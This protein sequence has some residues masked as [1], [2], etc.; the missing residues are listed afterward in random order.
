MLHF[1]RVVTDKVR[2]LLRSHGQVLAS[3]DIFVA[4]AQVG[5]APLVEMSVVGLQ[6][7]CLWLQVWIGQL[8]PFLLILLILDLLQKLNV[9]L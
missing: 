1:L 9:L 6:T 5:P 7:C 8:S 2:A 3:L 4:C